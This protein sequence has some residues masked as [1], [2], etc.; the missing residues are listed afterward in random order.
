MK[1]VVKYINLNIS[2]T[3][4][5]SKNILITAGAQGIGEAITK[6]SINTGA[7]LDINGGIYNM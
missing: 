3:Q 7:T 5:T 6:H 2:T 1:K 4:N